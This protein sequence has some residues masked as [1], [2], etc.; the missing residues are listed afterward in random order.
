M[1]SPCFVA[2]GGAGVC[3]NEEADE[4]I[5]G[6]ELQSFWFILCILTGGV[7]DKLCVTNWNSAVQG[8]LACLAPP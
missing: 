7:P 2:F 3:G 1:T 5:S 8:S 4:L 6:S